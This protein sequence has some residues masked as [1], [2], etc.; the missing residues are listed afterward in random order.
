MSV[1][2]KIFA[3]VLCMSMILALS[4]TAFADGL[5]PTSVQSYD[6]YPYELYDGKK[7]TLVN[8]T[9]VVVRQTAGGLKWPDD[10][11]LYIGYKLTV[12]DANCNYVNGLWWSQITPDNAHNPDYVNSGFSASYLL[13]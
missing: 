8:H 6:Q 5:M 9:E 7:V 4:L 3:F 1:I 2:K 11:T 10:N 12:E 13:N